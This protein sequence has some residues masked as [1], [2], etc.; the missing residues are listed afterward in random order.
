MRGGV[1][2]PGVAGRRLVIPGHLA[3]IGM[4]GED[5]GEIEI[6][7]AARR[8]QIAIPRIAIA[9]A[10]IEQIEFRIIGHGIPRR[11]ASPE[12]PPIVLAVGRPGFHRGRHRRV[13]GRQFRIA[14]HDEEA[15][16]LAAGVGVISSEIA[17]RIIF[18]AAVSDHDESVHDARRARD[19]V[20]AIAI[21]RV[22]VPDGFSGGGIEL[23]E[24][25]VQR[26]DIDRALPHRDAAIG[27]IAA[28][29]AAP[30]ARHLRI[31]SPELLAGFRIQ[32]PN[33]APRSRD[34][35]YAVRHHGRAFEAARGIGAEFP[36]HAE[37]LHRVA[38]DLRERR[39]AL[40]G[41]GASVGKPIGVGL[42][43]DFLAI[44]IGYRIRGRGRRGL[45][46][47]LGFGLGCGSRDGR[48]DTD[49]KRRGNQAAQ[50][51]KSRGER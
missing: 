6:V 24:T 14:G 10:D 42:M 23:D 13:F 2:V 44:H 29:I 8:T 18:R 16:D 30:C 45:R 33:L 15:P 28:G 35:H 27:N 39:K 12:L 49:G 36:R 17:A 25:A 34:I 7:A 38:V 26:A 22:D 4:N 31:V 37:V 51:Q 41:I 47:R 9:R 50:S 48:A 3:R 20:S 46:V 43:N 5:R 21:D 19:R 11:A 1:E 32:R 40:L